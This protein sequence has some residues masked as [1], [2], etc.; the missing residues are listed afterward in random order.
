MAALT[1]DHYTHASVIM[2][3]TTEMDGGGDR[4]DPPAVGSDSEIFQR[5]TAALNEAGIPFV[6]THHK[7]VFTSAEAATVRGVSLHSG[8]KA[9]IVKGGKEFVM[10]VLPA[11]MFLDSPALRKHLGC[12][13]LRFATKEEVLSMTGLTPGSIP[14]F[15]SLFNLVTICDER[16]AD[17]ERINFN[18]GSHTESI[19]MAYSAYCT[20]ESP[21]VA[22]IAKPAPRLDES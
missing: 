13:R 16:L 12:K 8:A 18:A 3:A 11:D 2:M 4:P 15:G 9:L 19:Q 21:R 6:H 5:L 20:H 10:A 7:A 22:G 17:N 14:P 1:L